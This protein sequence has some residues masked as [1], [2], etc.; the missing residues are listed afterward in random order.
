MF[1]SFSFRSLSHDCIFPLGEIARGNYCTLGT[2]KSRC[3]FCRSISLLTHNVHSCTSV[4]LVHCCLS[5]M[6]DVRKRVKSIVTPP[7]PT[8]VHGMWC[9]VSL[10]CFMRLA[11]HRVVLLIRGSCNFSNH[12]RGAK[13]IFRAR[14]PLLKHWISLN[15]VMRNTVISEKKIPVFMEGWL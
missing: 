12:S 3:G 8:R 7:P 11:E 4:I 10:V 15:T 2:H 13:P 6:E 5:M 14:H 9:H 1:G